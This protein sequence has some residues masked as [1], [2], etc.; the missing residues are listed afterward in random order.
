M[1]NKIEQL[2]IK[3]LIQEY[4]FLLLDDEYKKLGGYFTSYPDWFENGK[5]T[6]IKSKFNDL[7]D[8]FYKGFDK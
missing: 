2:E 3:K 8:W 5:S 7:P 4:N 6:F 1:K